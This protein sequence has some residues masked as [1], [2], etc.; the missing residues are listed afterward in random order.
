MTPARLERL[1]LE[2]ERVGVAT[3]LV[4]SP[5]NVRYLTG[6]AS[7]NA[8]L[9]VGTDGTRLVTDGRYVEAARG[10]AGVEVVRSSRDLTAFLAERLAGLAEAPVG[11]EAA[12]LTVVG[13][14][15]LRKSGVELVPTR[16]VVERLRAVKDEEEL[17]AIRRATGVTNAVYERLAAEGGVVGTTEAELAWRLAGFLHDGGA[18]EPAFPTIAA[19]GPNAALPHHH[20]GD[21][22]VRPDETLIVDLG[23]A[24]GGFASDCTRTFATGELPGDLARAYDVCREAQADALGAVRPGA[25]AREVDAI[26]RDRLQREG[27]DVLHGLGHGLG[28]EVHEAPRLADTSDATL[29]AGNVVT[30]EP[31]VYLPGRGGIRIEDLV[32]V[33]EEGPEILTAFTKDLVT[34]A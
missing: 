26:A 19:S 8:A 14:E 12:H 34:L 29:E 2:L 15:S 5:P 24:L 23:A 17:G 21:R 30:V 31:G 22:P 18:D 28:L 25:S 13:W 20:P 16:D 1:R 7:S 32:I 4:T 11:F 33:A 27:Y 6:F 10:V 3:L 9:L